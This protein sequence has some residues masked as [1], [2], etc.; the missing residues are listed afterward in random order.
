MSNMPFP[1][2]DGTDFHVFMTKP[3]GPEACPVC[4]CKE[5]HWPHRKDPG[6]GWAV[7]LP[8]E[9]GYTQVLYPGDEPEVLLDASKS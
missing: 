8:T 5:T 6:G 3:G 1:K 7:L 9:E 2:R 4:G